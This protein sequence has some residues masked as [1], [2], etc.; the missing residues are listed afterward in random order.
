MFAR[1]TIFLSKSEVDDVGRRID[2]VRLAARSGKTTTASNEHAC[3]ASHNAAKEEGWKPSSAKFDETGVMVCS[4]RHGIPLLAAS[5]DTPG[6]QQKYVVALYEHLM[7]LLPGNA[8]LVLLYDIGCVLDHSLRLYDFT[9]KGFRERL[10]L[11][12]S[13][14]HS[15]GH[16]WRCQ[17]IYNPRIRPGIG[18]TDGEGVERIWSLLRFLISKTRCSSAAMRMWALERQLLAIG[19]SHRKDLG[20]WMQTRHCRV[21]QELTEAWNK[22]LDC[23]VPIQEL[24]KEWLEQQRAEVSQQ[25][26]ED[27]A[28]IHKIVDRYIRLMEDEEKSSRSG[29][30]QSTTNEPEALQPQ[31]ALSGGKYDALKE[32][33]DTE[34]KSLGL[35]PDFMVQFNGVD[36]RFIKKLLTARVL[37]QKVRFK[38]IE[39]FFEYDRLAQSKSGKNA[40]LGKDVYVQTTQAISRRRPALM[41]AITTFNRCCEELKSLCR[42]TYTLQ[43]PVPL[44]TNMEALKEDPDLLQDVWIKRTEPTWLRQ[45][46]RVGIQAMLKADHCADEH[47]RICREAS[48][49]RRWVRVKLS[50]TKCAI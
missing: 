12:T 46:F 39:T 24:R 36:A 10:L 34:I 26:S 31:S 27:E 15:Y 8:T 45:D 48:L 25:C 33:M 2:S 18:L 14:M 9:L 5:I 22:L 17:I 40:T 21:L 6:E 42:P 43:I 38:V 49:M 41:R 7:Q 37:K 4:C 35:N 50:A 47:R 3:A 28:R 30:S 16:Q 44:P 32:S 1:P 23:G 13:V 19:D 29:N 20:K 11:C